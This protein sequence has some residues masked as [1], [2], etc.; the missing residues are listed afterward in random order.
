MR[1]Y[2]N[3]VQQLAK[4]EIENALLRFRQDPD[5]ESMDEADKLLG[6]LLEDCD[7]DFVY[8]YTKEEEE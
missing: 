2:I 5:L 6:I 8:Y 3:V 4:T 1:E 7:M